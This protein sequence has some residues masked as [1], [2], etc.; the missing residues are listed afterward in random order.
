MPPKTRLDRLVTVRERSEDHA[1][2]H[3]ARAQSSLESAAG[4]LTGLRQCARQDTRAPGAAE[5]WVMEEHAHLRALQ[6]VQKAEGEVVQALSKEQTA[7]S[8][9]AAAHRNAEVA[10]RVQ[11]KKRDEISAERERRER[12]AVDELSTQRFTASPRT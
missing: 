11:G 2:E 1:L 8:G 10:R 12:R 7:R 9:Y 4:R 6:Q 5:L 3:L